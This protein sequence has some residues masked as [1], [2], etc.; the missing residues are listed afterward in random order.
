MNSLESDGGYN[1]GVASTTHL[2]QLL[3]QRRDAA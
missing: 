2:G 1:D 3:L